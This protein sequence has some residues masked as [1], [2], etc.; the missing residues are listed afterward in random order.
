ME[1]TLVVY[2]SA[3]GATRRLGEKIADTLDA[4][5]FEIKPS[6]EYTDEDLRWPSRNNRSFMEMKNK[7][8]RPGILNNPE[9]IDEYNE[10]FIGFP[11]WYYTAPT[12]INTFIEQNDLVGKDVYVFVTSG[13]NTVDKSLKDLRKTYP[14]ISFISGKRFS[15]QFY[16]REVFSWLDECKVSV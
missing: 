3:G 12:I 8:Y 6:I 7:S 14:D 4:D 10:V 1:K 2:F 11:V 9:N 5:T 13:V 16:P 15:G